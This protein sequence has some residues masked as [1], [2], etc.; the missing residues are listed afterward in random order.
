MKHS[1]SIKKLIEKNQNE[2]TILN[3]NHRNMIEKMKHDH[4][5]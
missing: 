5:V 3:E 1:A 2:I 4:S